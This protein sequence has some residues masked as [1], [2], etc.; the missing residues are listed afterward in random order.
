M[1]GSPIHILGNLGQDPPV[2]ETFRTT[3]PADEESA[4]R[5]SFSVPPY[6][7]TGVNPNTN[8]YLHSDGGVCPGGDGDSAGVTTRYLDAIA[9]VAASAK[10]KNSALVAFARRQTSL[11]RAH[12]LKSYDSSSRRPPAD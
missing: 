11:E 6:D 8:L 7:G 5:F 10:C 4:G 1:S 2:G 3:R 12:R 9:P